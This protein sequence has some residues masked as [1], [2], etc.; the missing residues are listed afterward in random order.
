MFRLRNAHFYFYALICFV[1]PLTWPAQTG[2]SGSINGTVTDPTGAVVPGATVEIHNPVSQYSRTTTSDDAGK[3]SFPNVPFNPYHL[4]AT[5]KGFSQAAQDVEVRSSVPVTAKVTLPLATSKQV[6]TVQGEAGD[7]L[8]VDST[9]H[10]DVDRDL[11]Q[12]VPLES[13]SSALS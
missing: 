6:V 12:K 13:S 11:L 4:A 9:F 5:A 1:L 10:T 2:N 7:L 8:E 3:F